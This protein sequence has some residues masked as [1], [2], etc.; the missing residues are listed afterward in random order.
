MTK[1]SDS[2]ALRSFALID[3]H[4]PARTTISSMLMGAGHPVEPFDSIAQLP[5][6]WFGNRIILMRDETGAFDKL[7]GAADR[8]HIWPRV[9]LYADEP[10]PENIANRIKQGAVGYIV[11]PQRAEQVLSIVQADEFGG[12]FISRI[13]WRVYQAERALAG[14]TPREHEILS[15]VANGHTSRQIATLLDLSTRTVEVHR[16]NLLSKLG[17]RTSA[18]AVR[19]TVERSLLAS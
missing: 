14:L 2:S 9:I 6:S 13:K 10:S 19:L 4:P 11:T 5:P 7:V 1:S 12:S 15:L 16:A 18:E 3:P 8:E 17:A